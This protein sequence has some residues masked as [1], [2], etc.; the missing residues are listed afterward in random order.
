[1]ATWVRTSMSSVPWFVGDMVHAESWTGL[2]S[3]SCFKS[4]FVSI[5]LY[6]GSGVTN[7]NLFVINFFS[8]GVLTLFLC[9]ICF[10]F[11]FNFWFFEILNCSSWFG[12]NLE[13]KHFI[14][15]I[16]IYNFHR[17]IV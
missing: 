8:S 12:D 11:F 6:F 10:V 15:Y 9:Y 5:A 14:P 1:M 2:P 7:K 17:H 3:F 4:R 16:T 13:I